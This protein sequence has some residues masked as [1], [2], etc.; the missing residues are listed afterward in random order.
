[1]NARD[2]F[3]L[4]LARGAGIGCIRPGPG[5]WGSVVGLFWTA[6]LLHGTSRAVVVVGAVTAILVSIPI[7][8]RAS[9]LLREPDPASVV[10]DEIVAVPIV[11]AVPFLLEPDFLSRI[12]DQHRWEA[13]GWMGLG[14]AAFRL[15]DI[16]KPWPIHPLQRLPGGLGIVADDLAAAVAATGS[17]ELFRLGWLGFVGR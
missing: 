3:V 7:C 17:W 6:L 14:F 15:F 13:C 10:L 16:V 2:Q 12:F 9:R 4:F 5:T 8:G 11:F 1:M